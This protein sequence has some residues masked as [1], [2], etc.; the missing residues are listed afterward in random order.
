MFAFI[1]Q[2]DALLLVP[3]LPTHGV[4]F[5]LDWDQSYVLLAALPYVLQ[6]L[7]TSLS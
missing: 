1:Y 3:R 7:K 5:T 6:L 2:L 4:Y